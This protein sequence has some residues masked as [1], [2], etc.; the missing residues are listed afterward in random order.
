MIAERS[1]IGGPFVENEAAR[2]LAKIDREVWI[3]TSHA[4][5]GRRGGLLATW[6]QQIT[7]EDSRPA[8]LIA[9]HPNHYTRELLDAS[10][11]FVAHLLSEH[12]TQLALAFANRSG[13]EG[14]KLADIKTETLPCGAPRLLDCVAW[15]QAKVF[16]R[17]ATPDRVYYWADCVSGG[18]ES[19]APPLRE[20]R[21][22]S[23]LSASDRAKLKENRLQDIEAVAQ[24]SAAWRGQLPDILRFFP[25]S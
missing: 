19:T 5:D 8:V 25:P 3:I 24:S 18:V 4:E 12:Q 7:L 2:A 22:F 16:S 13:R 10:G 1:I 20:A 14:D 6:V 23:S 11:A 21:F 15:V 17:L 9:L